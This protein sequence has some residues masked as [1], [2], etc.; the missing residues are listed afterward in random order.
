MDATAPPDLCDPT[1]PCQQTLTC[2]DG[3]LYPTSC[4]AANCDSPL[5]PCKAAD[6]GACP[7][8]AKTGGHCSSEGQSCPLGCTSCGMASWEEVI[9][10]FCTCKAGAWACD[11]LTLSCSPTAPDVYEDPSCTKLRT[12]EAGADGAKEAASN[13]D[14]GLSPDL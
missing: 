8:T 1:L 7:V 9:D 5:G 13:L 4:G 14:A 11:P 12:P 3:G 2:A 6:A 10:T